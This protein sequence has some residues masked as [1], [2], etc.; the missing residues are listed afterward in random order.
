MSIASKV[1]LAG[2]APAAGALFGGEAGI[3]LQARTQDQLEEE[4]RRRLREA[5]VS[6]LGPMGAAATGL[7]GD[8]TSMRGF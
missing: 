1:G 7:F 4:R 6:R 2:L 3:D 8:Y 5:Q